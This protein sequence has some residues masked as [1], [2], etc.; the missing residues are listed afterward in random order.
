MGVQMKI[1]FCWILLNL[2]LTIFKKIKMLLPK[3]RKEWWERRH[4]MCCPIWWIN[5]WKRCGKVIKGRKIEELEDI[6]IF[7][8]IVDS[9]SISKGPKMVEPRSF[10]IVKCHQQ[11]KITSKRILVWRKLKQYPKM[12]QNQRQ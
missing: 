7:I 10:M 11:S 3:N 8:L 4:K 6:I 5:K 1:H 12:K 9:H 2:T